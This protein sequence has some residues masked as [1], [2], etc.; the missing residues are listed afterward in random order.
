MSLTTFVQNNKRLV[1]RI[2][3][4]LGLFLLVAGL[5]GVVAD[6]VH[7]GDT[8]A[9]DQSV[10]QAIN[11]TSTPELDRFFLILTEFGGV[12]F[13]AL[14]TI[15]LFCYLIYKKQRYNA[16]LLGAGVGGAAL[17]NYLA[18]ITFVRERPDLWNQLITETTYSFPSGHAAGSSAL[19]ICIVAIL[20]QTRW[21][22]P[23]LILAAIYIPLIGYSR[24]YLGVHY[25]TDIT[26]GW[27]LSVAWATVVISLFYTRRSRN[28]FH[29]NNNT[30]HS[31]GS[32]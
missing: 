27:I 23:A 21:R 10:L 32:L 25:L 4:S 9:F 13:V 31:K 20:W 11:K 18:K 15:A 26:A 14:V 22:I 2:G 30:T 8:L 17:I 5:F 3:M 1:T 6:N 7:E 19:A 12:A 29:Q 24:M 28:L 16:L